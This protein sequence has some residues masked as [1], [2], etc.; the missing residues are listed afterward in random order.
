MAMHWTQASALLSVLIGSLLYWMLYSLGAQLYSIPITP[1]MPPMPPDV[2]YSFSG[3]LCPWPASA[4]PVHS[5]VPCQRYCLSATRVST[6]FALALC[7]STPPIEQ[8]HASFLHFLSNS[9]ISAHW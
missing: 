1:A 9:H 4:V 8:L 3:V 2:L 7:R 5:C 6:H